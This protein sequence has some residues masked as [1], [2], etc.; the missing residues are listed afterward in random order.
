MLPLA[1]EAMGEATARL[2]GLLEIQKGLEKLRS[3]RDRETDKRWQ[4]NYDLLLAQ[5]VAYQVKAFEYRACVEEMAKKRPKPKQ[6]PNPPKLE[7]WWGFGHAKEPKAPK[8]KTAKKYAEAERLF[9]EVIEHYPN[10]PWADMAQDELNRG[11]SVAWGEVDH[12]PSPTRASREKF[13]PKY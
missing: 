13:V 10:T 1:N 8:E 5:V 11:L 3:L 6:M 9:K 12:A 4:A 2:N 7:V